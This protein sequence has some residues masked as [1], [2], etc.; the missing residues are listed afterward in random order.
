[1]MQRHAG[2]HYAGIVPDIR[3]SRIRIAHVRITH[4]GP[5]P[6]GFPEKKA[7]SRRSSARRIHAVNPQEKAAVVVS[8]IKLAVS[9]LS[10]PSQVCDRLWTHTQPTGTEQGS[11]P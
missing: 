10:A 7:P 8:K 11:R 2:E 4:N 1:M 3:I 9:G 6:D 5:Q